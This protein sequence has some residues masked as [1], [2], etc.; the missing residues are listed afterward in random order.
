VTPFLGH[1]ALRGP[2]A[3]S[4]RLD[5]RARKGRKGPL[6]RKGVQVIAVNPV[7]RV[8][9]GRSGRKDPKVDWARKDQP[10]L[11]AKAA[12]LDRKVPR[13]RPVLPGPKAPRAILARL[14]PSASLP[15]R[16]WLA[17]RTTNFWSRSCVRPA[18]PKARSAPR[19]ARQ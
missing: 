17:A 12:K 5:L 18:P 9:K 4:V 11:A 16:T 10:A 19:P 8:R 7:L 15:E 2:P 3:K 13:A 6:A 1:K 14:R